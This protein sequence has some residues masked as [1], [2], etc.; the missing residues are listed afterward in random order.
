[1]SLASLQNR[2][3]ETTFGENLDVLQNDTFINGDLTVDGVINGI[4]DQGQNSNNIWVG[5]NEWSVDRPQ[6]VPTLDTVPKAGVNLELEQKKLVDES[7]VNKGKTWTGANTFTQDVVFPNVPT[8]TPVNATDGC[9][10]QYVKSLWATKDQTSYLSANNT[11]TNTNIFSPTLPT[12]LDPVN[13]TDVATKKYVDTVT[14]GFTGG[15][16]KTAI[17]QATIQ[18]IAWG[19]SAVAVE[20]QI[21]GGGGGA[22]QSNGNCGNCNGAGNAGASSASGS[23]LVL[24]NVVGTP[25]NGNGLFTIDVGLGG[26]YNGGSCAT[27]QNG[28]AT[29][30]Y[31]TTPVGSGLNPSLVNVLRANGGGSTP[32]S[33]PGCKAFT[34]VGG[35]WNSINPLL[36][37]PLGAS[38]GSNGGPCLPQIVMYTGINNYGRGASGAQCQN[39]TTGQSGGYGLV[40]FS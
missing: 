39:A 33:Q 24:T 17:S 9:P 27:A 11:W 15:T 29:N 8:P 13:D 14:S 31:V 7:P 23:M 3:T 30:F 38:G 21:I 22:T 10:A 34:P 35:T 12:V 37:K 2:V 20:L 40:F 18:S 1:M 32:D 28:N 4:S 16:L 19:Q 5:T 25:G 6:C 36:V 26:K